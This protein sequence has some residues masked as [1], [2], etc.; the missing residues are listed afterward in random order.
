MKNINI[1]KGQIAKYAL[2]PQVAPRINKLFFSGFANLAYFLALVYRAVNILPDGH[3][4]LERSSV[5]RY[6]IRNVFSEAASHINFGLH[7][8]DKIIIFFALIA[9][10]I[11]LFFQFFIL[12]TAII[13]NPASAQG[14]TG[15]GIPL[16]DFFVTPNPRE[17]LAL[18]MLDSVFGVPDI[19]G[20]MD[21]AAVPSSFH[22]AL[23]GLFQI[24][25]FALL[26]IAAIILA[27]FV[28]AVLAETAQTGT[29]FG[30]RYNHIWAPIRLVVGI[31]MLVPITLGLN[32]GQW[33][34]LYAAKLGSGFATQGWILFDSQVNGEYI[35]NEE[36][37]AVP[38]TPN[39]KDLMAFMM[40]AHGCKIGFEAKYGT[41]LPGGIDMYVIAPDR[42]GQQA[43]DAPQ[44]FYDVTAFVGPTKP[45]I[46]FGWRNPAN[47]SDA[48]GG[49]EPLC[50]DLVIQNTEDTAAL[51]AAGAGSGVGGW[52]NYRFYTIVYE[53]WNRQNPA[54]G[55]VVEVA[56]DI[57][58]KALGNEQLPPPDAAIKKVLTDAAES[59]TDI[60]I[61]FAAGI[62]RT[63]IEDDTEAA[64]YGWGGA[65]LWYNQIADNNGQLTSAAINSPQVKSYPDPMEETCAANDAENSNTTQI[66]CYSPNLS[67]GMKIDYNSEVYAPIADGLS[68][69]FNYWYRDTDDKTGNAFMPVSVF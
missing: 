40:L 23:H 49:V 52:L 4:Y 64:R 11:I 29:P 12:A 43:M 25:S 27:Y 59:Y 38:E 60:S 24:Y 28:F 41:S 14:I 56:E 7:N 32:A 63:Q 2:L 20:S 65:S 21:S 58:A 62:A 36:M 17:D 45:I 48:V 47:N 1:T 61:L 8:L 42:I 66:E 35:E 37:I 19:F 68:M 55:Q 31:G 50:G 39:L 26:V 51:Q 53:I 33:I 67:S 54:Y 44:N 18:R 10:I 13:I 57:M 34:T 30:K 69:I 15:L 6:S 16:A 22:T 9:G 3:V 46:R 5:G